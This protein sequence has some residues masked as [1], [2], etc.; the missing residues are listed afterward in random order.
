MKQLIKVSINDTR[1]IFRDPTLRVFFVLPLVLY[2]LVLWFLPSLVE[3]YSFLTPYLSAI[4][5]LAV[6]E[7]TQT[8]CIICS[9]VFVEEKET[10]VAKV[11]GVLPVSKR[12]FV[13]SRMFIPFVFTIMLNVVLLIL[14]PF[15][16]IGILS[17]TLVSILSGLIVPIYVLIINVYV[18]NKVEALMYIKLLNIFVLLPLA[19]FFLP[20]YFKIFF[21]ILPTHWLFQSLDNIF[22]HQNYVVNLIIGYSFF[23]TLLIYFTNR[24]VK[25]HFD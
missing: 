17:V 11:Y 14:Q 18:K 19:A 3:E 4:L 23:L 12:A 9:M 10:Y 6:I 16:S 22:K 7:N 24:F 1:L 25:K 8:F 21:G 13:L 20:G 15:F 5:V 2:L